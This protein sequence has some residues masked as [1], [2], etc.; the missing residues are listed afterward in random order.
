ML[1]GA[2]QVKRHSLQGDPAKGTKC[3][4]CRE[5]IDEP[6]QPNEFAFGASSGLGYCHG[7][8]LDYMVSRS[9]PTDGTE[10][11]MRLDAIWSWKLRGYEPAAKR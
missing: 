10:R 2:K 9:R 7:A 3:V 4:F 5:V 6:L 8:C 1:S 11:C